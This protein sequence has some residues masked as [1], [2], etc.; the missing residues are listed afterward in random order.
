MNKI[1]RIFTF[2]TFC[3]T[4]RI[5]LA[6]LAKYLSPT[7]LQYMGYITLIPAFGFLYLYFSNS[8]LNAGEGGGKTWWH[9]FKLNM[10]YYI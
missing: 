9:N 1:S 6:L 10:D 3:L 5:S 7:S 4:A 8:R 2:I